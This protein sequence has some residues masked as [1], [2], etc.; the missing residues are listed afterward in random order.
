MGTLKVDTV[1]NVAGSGAPDA[2]AVTVDNVALSSLPQME[3]AASGTEPTSP[4]VGSLW[5]NTAS[6][7]FYMYDGEEWQTVTFDPPPSWF[8]GR[9]VFAAGGNFQDRIEYITISTPGNST[10]FGDLIENRWR[11]NQGLSNGSRGVTGG[12]LSFSNVIQYVTIATPG[13]ATDF[14]DL[15]AARGYC[16]G[17]GDGTKGLFGGGLVS[18]RT[19]AID[20]ITVATTGNATDFGDL[21]VARDTS[22]GAVSNGTRGVFGGGYD[23]GGTGSYTVMD[24]VTI[25]TAGNATDFGDM[26]NFA[27]GTGTASGSRGLFAGGFNGSYSDAIQYITI[28]TTSNTS[29]FGDLLAY[30][31]EPASCASETRAVFAGGLSS[32]SYTNSIQYVTI[33]TTGNGTDFGDMISTNYKQAGFSG[34]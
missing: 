8:G 13:N 29:D 5:Y 14:G 17:L 9:G 32:P 19:A 6:D 10:D 33:A 31:L 15:T 26:N 16:S 21:T 23:N 7:K 2:A 34:D 25:A 22:N 28:D 27:G 11:P 30:A 24:Y 20:V 4:S 3:Y 12:G 1:T 18:N